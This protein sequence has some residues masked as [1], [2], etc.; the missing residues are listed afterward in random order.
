MKTS[1]MLLLAASAAAGCK[2]TAASL[3]ES[4]PARTTAEVGLAQKNVSIGHLAGNVVVLLATKADGST[5]VAPQKNADGTPKLDPT[6]GAPVMGPVLIVRYLV[7]GTFMNAPAAGPGVISYGDVVA[8]PDTFNG[9]YSPPT[10]PWDCAMAAAFGVDAPEDSP[11]EIAGLP[12]ASKCLVEFNAIGPSPLT[13]APGATSQNGISFAYFGLNTTIGGIAGYTGT[14]PLGTNKTITDPATGATIDLSTARLNPAD[15]NGGAPVAPNMLVDAAAV[16]ATME[17][18]YT[19]FSK[20]TGQVDEATRNTC[21][22]N[23]LEGQWTDLASHV[24]CLLPLWSDVRTEYSDTLIPLTKASKQKLGAGLITQAQFGGEVLA[25]HAVSYQKAV[26]DG[27]TAGAMW[28]KDP[29]NA[30]AAALLR[31]AL[32][33]LPGARDFNLESQAKVISDFYAAVGIAKRP[34]RLL[35]IHADGD[36]AHEEYTPMQPR[37]DAVRANQLVVCKAK[38]LLD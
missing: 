22:H 5:K 31:Y 27:T 8:S 33:T 13:G 38:G 37:Y 12:Q 25:A 3:D 16:Q 21:L 34:L 20:T 17:K 29:A 35:D 32:R 28:L 10:A 2:T 7:G 30:D 11:A 15:V 19:Q 18:M 36:P 23:A 6:T 24:Y 14:T 4:T 9:K 26:T 1:L